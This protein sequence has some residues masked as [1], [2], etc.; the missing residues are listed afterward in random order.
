MA[1]TDY[2]K[3]LG[4]SK[5]STDADI[6]K[7]YRTKARKH[8]PDV[9]K[10]PDAETKFKEINEAYQVLSDPQKKQTYDQ[11]GHSA[12]EP[13][14]GGFSGAGAAQG[15]NPF[16][17]GFNSY[18][19]SSSGGQGGQDAGGFADPFD[20]FEAF[21]GGQS[22]FGRQQRLP[23]YAIEI[24]FMDA[25]H[26]VQKEIE[27]DGKKHKIKIPPG[28]DSGSE[29]RFSSFILICQ[30]KTSSKFKRRGSDIVSEHEI[31]YS[32]A[33]LGTVEEIETVDGSVKIKIPSG[34]QP[35]TQIRLK[36]KGVPNI[37]GYGTGDF[38]IYCNVWTPQK[39]S[40]EEK[41]LLEKLKSSDNFRPNPTIK[42]KGFF[43]RMKDYFN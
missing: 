19:W 7:A 6:K 28:V 20:I 5:N 29:I 35:G 13:G 14:A 10:S 38:L 22:P 39:L 8:H 11:F 27:I 26:G 37:H 42:D 24:D 15:G 30:V 23:R 18:S 31:S 12:F 41:E 32:Q 4:V 25:I 34:T 16:S 9:D 40:K 3:V 33:A 43:D 2:Y 1:K 17:G 21:F 36:G